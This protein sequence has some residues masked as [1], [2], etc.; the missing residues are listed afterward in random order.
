MLSY[1]IQGVTYGFAAAVQPGPLQAYIIL[2][3]LK[4]GWRRSIVYALVPLLSDLPI[5]ALVVTVLA[6]LPA[7]WVIVLRL[8]GGVFLIYLA[9]GAFR[10]ALH[11]AEETASPEGSPQRGLLPAVAIN[12]LNPNPYLFWSLV[13]GPIL[14]TG[15]K[16]SP[17][18]AVAM[19]AA[20]YLVMI[21]VCAV[22]ILVVS[23]AHRFNPRLRQWLMIASA[24]GLGIFG[25]YQLWM[26]ITGKV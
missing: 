18:F 13:A 5:I 3:A 15:W 4:N 9:V 21:I 11:P 14:L 25:A 19:L 22:I 6:F 16:E 1:I 24:I 20:F 8:A 7:G 23:I 10:T 12:L 2:Q 26:G 17:V